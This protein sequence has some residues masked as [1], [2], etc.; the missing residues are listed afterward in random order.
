M[1]RR[2][3]LRIAAALATLWI[4]SADG[5]AQ[6]PVV[7]P[8]PGTIRIGV[9]QPDGR[10]VAEAIPLEDY[11]ARVLS[12]EGQPKAAPAAQ[13]ALAIVIRTFALA[14]RNR[15]RGE[16]Y[17]L[18]DTTHC[19]V[20]R[21]VLP[22]AKAAAEAT[23]GRV[24]LDR[25]RPAFVFY[26]AHDGG[27]PAL[28]SEVWPGA[29]DY[30]PGEPEDV[31]GD[32]PGWTSDITTAEAER[33]LRAAGLSGRALKSLTIV[34][35]T[36]SG[37]VGRL[38]AEGFTPDSVAANDFRLAAGRTI[39]GQRVRSTAFELAA[40]P[41]GYHLSGV[42]YGHGVGLCVIGAGKRAL[43][44]QDTATIL[45]AYFRD[46]TVSGAPLATSP[47]L[48][49]GRAA[50][51][52]IAA[53]PTPAVPR[54][55]TPAPPI[56]PAAVLATDI[57]LT[58]PAFE[59]HDRALVLGLARQTRDAVAARALVAAPDAIAIQVHPDMD[60]FGRATGQ[61][62]WMTGATVGT[63]IDLAPLEQL[64]QRGVL[65]SAIRFEVASAVVAPY[66]REAPAWVRVG[67]AL[68]YITPDR[69]T[70]VAGS[71]R[72]VCPTDG[73]LLRPVSG[74]A[75]REAMLRAERCVRREIARGRRLT[76]LR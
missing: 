18:C 43:R 53:P 45:R 6:A 57:R 73:E 20:M 17:D 36:A 12:G 24:L 25:G 46:L 61:P 59:E 75:Q 56:A 49:S 39:G 8:A 7:A 35:R 44:G 31:C 27:R 68:F 14:N 16:G 33:A 47:T 63:T 54:P 23:A 28:A 10:V 26:S 69:A 15:H 62:W 21:P 72:L 3:R 70:D 71:A 60:A 67:A 64:R 50:P 9:T 13:Q 65:E 1:I 2:R 34:D 58:L 66:L 41:T 52:S 76:D 22:A 19:Q 32:E 5:R 29:V 40:T 74:G 42:G 48:S 55:V 51:P 4:A 38:R 11:V 37:R 30:A